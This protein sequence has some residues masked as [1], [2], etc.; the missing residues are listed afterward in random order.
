[1][2][3]LKYHI[4]IFVSVLL[5]LS[6]CIKEDL[7]NC[8]DGPT[9]QI[10]FT[11]DGT[12]LDLRGAD[13]GK[14]KDVSIYVF[15]ANNAFLSCH[16]FNVQSSILDDRFYIT[17]PANKTYSFVAW[18]NLNSPFYH[19]TPDPATPGWQR[20]EARLICTT[21]PIDDLALLFFGE[22]PN[23]TVLEVDNDIVYIPLVENT[24]E[25]HL[26]VNGLDA[27]GPITVEVKDDNGA[28]YFDNEFAPSDS[29]TYKATGDIDNNMTL[30]AIITVLDLD[31]DR[32]PLLTVKDKDG[33][34]IPG[35]EDIDFIDLIKNEVP[36]YDFSAEREHHIIISLDADMTLTVTIEDWNVVPDENIEVTTE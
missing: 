11:Y 3:Q 12:R 19:T 24:H 20:S 15:D 14:V 25:V 4:G 16:T 36:G 13:A 17:L 2:N 32:S 33:N 18:T 23:V 9:M 26:T 22:K 31:N 29:V 7:S 27:L 10:M 28:Y 6:S 8:P 34:P 1:M 35:L 21:E 5:L 30:E